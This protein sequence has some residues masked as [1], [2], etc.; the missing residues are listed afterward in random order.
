MKNLIHS[1]RF[2]LMLLVILAAAPIYGMMLYTITQQHHSQIVSIEEGSDRLAG[3]VASEEEQ[4]LVTTYELLKTLAAVPVVQS[5]EPISCG[6]FLGSLLEENPHYVNLGGFDIQGNVVCSVL[7][8]TNPIPIADYAWFKHAI[9]SGEFTVGEYQVSPLT[10]KDIL[11][12]NYPIVDES[13]QVTRV[14][15]AAMDLSWLSQHEIDIMQQLPVG[16]TLTKIDRNGIVLSRQPYPEK[17]VGNPAPQPLVDEVLSRGRGTFEISDIDGVDRIYSFA[18]VHSVLHSGDIYVI[19]GIPKT[20]LFKDSDQLL[21]LTLIVLSSMTLLSLAC[22]WIFGDVLFIRRARSILNAAK[23]LGKGDFSA[24]TGLSKTNGEVGQ[25]AQAFD[26]MAETLEQHEIERKQR[27]RE[28]ETVVSLSSAL[29]AASSR[30]D[31]LPIVLDQLML[32]MR[33]DVTILATYDAEGD[34]IIVELTRGYPVDMK[35][36]VRLTL[37]ERAI[38]HVIKTGQPYQSNNVLDDPLFTT[39]YRQSRVQTAIC[40]PLIAHGQMIGALEIGRKDELSEG[41]LRLLAAIAD[42][43]ANAIQRATLRERMEERLQHLVSLSAIDTSI[44]SSTD[45]NLTLNVVIEQVKTQLHVDAACVMLVNPQTQV[46]EYSVGRGFR[47]KGIQNSRLHLGDGKAGSAALER[48][49]ERIADPQELNESFLRDPSL[50]DENFT[51]Y[52]G[53]PLIAKGQVKG[54]LEVFNRTPL[55]ST[56]EWLNFFAALANQAAIAIDN[57]MLF[58]GLQRS[59]IEL[60][61]AYDSTIAGWSAALDL[62]DRETEGHTQRVTEM[63]LQLARV[64][65]MSEEELVD[66]RRGALLHDIGKMGI[67]DRILLKPG[68]LTNKE[69][70]IMRK[71]PVYAYEL[72]SP[73]DHLRQALDIPYCHHEKWD[74]NGYPRGL[75]GEQIPLAARIFVVVDV[76]DALTSDRPYRKAWLKA[77]ARQYIRQQAGKHFDPRVVNKFLEILTT[78]KKKR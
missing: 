62:R 18:P 56:P 61:R 30:A 60:S 71:H 43:V 69:L 40:L 34:R 33:A 6:N 12:F 72:L 35:P 58:D 14:L 39:T 73:I 16:A 57:A 70:A 74:G 7:P 4:L 21:S 44:I 63:T 17:W 36:G 27:E 67:P 42:I 59:N 46:L 77:K 38:G 24:R 45:L 1:V 9:Q 19:L 25:I 5:G 76:W 55:D 49:I 75:K 37:G 22:V 53:V 11:R 47:T 8:V 50:K 66:V 32:L 68:P 29:R 78:V 23:R 10:D 15:F 26:Q 51:H 65:G 48:R 41:D 52:Y 13:G 31:M 3:L 28:L 20:A 64:M 2:R 54:V